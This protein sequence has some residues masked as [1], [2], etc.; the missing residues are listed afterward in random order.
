MPGPASKGRGADC[1][2]H[3]RYPG[4][5]PRL[6]RVG[7]VGGQ[8]LDRRQAPARPLGKGADGECEQ[9]PERKPWKEGLEAGPPTQAIDAPVAGPGAGPRQGQKKGG[10]DVGFEQAGEEVGRVLLGVQDGFAGGEDSGRDQGAGQRSSQG[11]QGPTMGR[12]QAWARP[13][14]LAQK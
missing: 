4:D 11:G 6:D 7:K 5:E 14:S 8:E 12:A 13:Q 10:E 9:A 3:H 1:E 2:N